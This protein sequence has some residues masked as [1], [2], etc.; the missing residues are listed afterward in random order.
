MGDNLKRSNAD[1]VSDIRVRGVSK[2][3]IQD[4]I[5]VAANKGI[6]LNNLLKTTITEIRNSFPEDKRMPPPAY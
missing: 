6:T 5:N 2:N 3:I 1:M 4:L